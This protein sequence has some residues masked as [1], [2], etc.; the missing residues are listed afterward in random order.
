MV[1]PGRL[2]DVL[3]ELAGSMTSDASML[4]VVDA[5]VGC[6]VRVLPVTGAAAMLIVPGTDSRYVVGSDEATRLFEELQL[7]SGAGPAWLAQETGEAVSITDLHADG[8]F[9]GLV[10]AAGGGPA[11]V[12]SLPLR[13]DYDRFGS[14]DL[15]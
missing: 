14:I 7:Q 5:L 1:D 9:A 15:F 10:A 8:R 3:S 2:A 6:I 13:H 4:G 11:A 12:F